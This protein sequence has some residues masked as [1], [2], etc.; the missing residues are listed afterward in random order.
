M[1]N[2]PV[3]PAPYAEALR[4]AD[5][6]LREPLAGPAARSQPSV[7]DALREARFAAYRRR[8]DVL[9]PA[10]IPERPRTRPDAATAEAW[11]ARVA[12]YRTRLGEIGVPE[13]GARAAGAAEVSRNGAAAAREALCRHSRVPVPVTPRTA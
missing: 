2:G 3:D 13:H 10:Q 8:A 1:G 9:P 5:P 7:L 6:R 12:A 11:N 4:A